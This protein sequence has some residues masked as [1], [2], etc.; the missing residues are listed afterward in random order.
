MPNGDNVLLLSRQGDKFNL[1]YYNEK[2][3]S[4][5]KI[6]EEVNQIYKGTKSTKKYVFSRKK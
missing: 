5:K 1:S 3:N 6:S 2:D 4:F